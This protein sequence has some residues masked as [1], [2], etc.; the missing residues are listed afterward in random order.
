MVRYN[1]TH[2]GQTHQAIVLAAS[3]LLREKGFTETSVTTVMKAVGLTHGGFYAHFEDKSAMLSAA[4]QEAFV[5][6]P[7]NFKVMAD[8]AKSQN[9]AGLIAQYY[10]T[11]SRVQN[12]ASGCPAAALV[13]ELPRQDESVRDAFQSGTIATLE[14]LKKTPGLSNDSWAALSMLVGG[15]VLMRALP[16]QDTNAIIRNQII[17]ALRMLANTDKIT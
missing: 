14:A 7:Q 15:L 4:V 16:D 3:T 9:D 6:S 5:E 10:L 12:V 13:S 2:H 1:K 11:E 17:S 8:M